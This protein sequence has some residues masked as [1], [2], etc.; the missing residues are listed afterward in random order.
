MINFTTTIFLIGL[1][2]IV[3]F[4]NKPIP[5]YQLPDDSLIRK[6]EK[7]RMIKAVFITPD[8]W[9]QSNYYTAYKGDNYLALSL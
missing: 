8:P 6:R 9:L 2:I 7:A 1:F 3:I 4:V 5:K